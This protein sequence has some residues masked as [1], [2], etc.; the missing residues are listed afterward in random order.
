MK[1]P[2]SLLLPGTLLFAASC[3]P[4]A[5]SARTF[6]PLRMRDYCV[7][8]TRAT[9]RVRADAD[10]MPRHILRGEKEW[11]RVSV[12]DWTSGFW[13]GILWYAYECSGDTVLQRAAEG[14]TSALAQLLE[15]PAESHDLG[16]MFFCSYGQAFRLTG[17]PACKEMVL[18][19]ADSLATLYHPRVGT[20]LSWPGMRARMGWPH[21]TI[22]DNMMNLELLFWAAKHGGSP[23]LAEIAV[24]H[25]ETSMRT[26][27]RPDYSVYHVGVFDT[28]DGHFI[29]GVT[30]QGYSDS[31]MWARGQAWAIYG[32]TVAYRETGK[33]EFLQTAR[34]LADRFLARLP[35]DLIP[36]W[37][38]DDPSI[39]AAP[40]DAAAAAIAASALLELGQHVT[41]PAAA[42]RY[43]AAAI[44]LLSRLSTPEYLGGETC[45]AFLRHATGHKPAGSEIDASLIYADYY[46]LEALMRLTR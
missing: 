10:S 13:P 9:L 16:F 25:A 4:A 19:A 31:S 44:A 26:L 33:A 2:T 39:P 43:R 24:R 5:P 21:N 1:I 46:Y 11:N 15:V 29:K 23:R 30:V 17:D 3:H 37:D 45:Q 28:T 8:K 36:Y 6:D 22:I 7:A 42:Q 40:R 20:I 38:F 27:I 32:Y 18:R 12:H 34:G 14:A 35:A 41:G